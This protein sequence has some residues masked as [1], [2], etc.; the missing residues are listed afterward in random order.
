MNALTYL[1]NWGMNK[2]TA[3]SGT[4]YSLYKALQKYYDIHDVNLSGN[5]WVNAFMHRI[6]RMDGMS[7]DYYRRK[8]LG[9]QLKNVKG[10]VFQFSEVLSNTDGRK[11]F[12]YVD[13]TV[14]YVNYLRTQLPEIYAVSAFQDSNPKILER[15]AN[16]QNDYISNHCSGLFTMGHWLRDWLIKQGVDANLVHAVG[17]GVQR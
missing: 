11:T 15:R 4:N 17:G 16:E 10:P 7:M 6:L 12:M 14:D 13:N 8:M 1:V 9:H 2:E 5:R 3:W